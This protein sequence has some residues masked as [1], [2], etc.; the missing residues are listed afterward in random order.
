MKK[1]ITLRIDT[2]LLEEIQQLDSVTGFLTKAAISR[3]N[4]IKGSKS[5]YQKK[6]LQEKENETENLDDDAKRLEYLKMKFELFPED[7][8]Q[9]KKEIEEIEKNAFKK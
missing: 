4:W 3:L 9:I 5:Y 1:L 6:E 2:E 7:Q 8:V